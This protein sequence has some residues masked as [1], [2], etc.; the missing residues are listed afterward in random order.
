MQKLGVRWTIGD[1]SE[2]G[3]EALM[4][5]IHGAWTIFGPETSYTVC[6]N[7][8]P[9][10]AARELVGDVPEGITWHASRADEL[11]GIIRQHVDGNMSEGVSWKFAPLQLFPDRHE[12]ALDNDLIMWEM[13][14]AVR[15][16]LETD[17]PQQ[18][19]V[20][21]DVRTCFGQFRQFCG[22]DPRNLGI[23]GLP[24]GFDLEQ[25]LREILRRHPVRLTSELDEQGL[26]CAALSL[27]KPPLFVSTDDV[28]ICS[29]FPPHFK[30]LGTCGA[31]FAGLNVRHS[32]WQVDGRPATE[33]IR[34]HWASHRPAIYKHVGADRARSVQCGTYGCR[35]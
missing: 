24:P 21:E 4:L 10:D 22:P 11:P 34:E 18:S 2:Q 5:S 29:P 30:S 15:V 16:W 26:Q 33:C 6:V 25:A 31:H 14:E 7:T 32:P 8:I 35:R 19:L 1:V 17:D 13:P 12:L 27:F 3:F 9:L 28:T 20:A 23:R